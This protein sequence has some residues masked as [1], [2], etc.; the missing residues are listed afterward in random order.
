M[1]CM[2]RVQKDKL[3]PVCGKY[4][5]CLYAEDGSA[6]ICARITEGSKKRCGDAGWLHI[7]VDRTKGRKH[8]S[9]R[10]FTLTQDNKSSKNFTA[11]KQRYSRQITSQQLDGLSRLLGVSG[12][13]LRR[14][15]C[16]WDGKAFCFP[17]YNEKGKT[18]GIRRRFSNGRKYSVKGSKTGLFIPS[19]L[20]PEGILLICEG[21]TDTAAALDLGFDAIGR[22]NCNSKIEMTA[23]AVRGRSE[24]VIISDNDTQGK[25]GAE[26][27]ADALVLHYPKIKIIN[28]PDGIKDLRQ[29]LR[30]GIDRTKL[31]TIIENTKPLTV[32]LTR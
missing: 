17:M 9:Q 12:E 2:I 10:R 8:S 16:G 7:L 14:L 6:A 23:K 21:P 26:K 32:E 4:D 20:L 29:W 18:I 15:S 3:C 1:F 27:L 11:L 19:G 13:S 24:I 25:A 31:L 28:P 22:P 30:E 5:W